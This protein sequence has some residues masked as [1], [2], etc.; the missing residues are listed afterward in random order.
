MPVGVAVGYDTSKQ[1]FV[2]EFGN[3]VPSTPININI[4]GNNPGDGASN[5]A[6]TGTEP[7]TGGD[8]GNGTVI[9]ANGTSTAAIGTAAPGTNIQW[10]D[11]GSL[12]NPLINAVKGLFAQFG[13]QITDAEALM[14]VGFL[15]VILVIL[16][17]G[18]NRR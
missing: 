15:L 12:L 5:A 16:A 14:I 7:L 17:E 4:G 13:I 1:A 11:L 10:P 9:D 3:V 2:D 18:R 6:P 8:T